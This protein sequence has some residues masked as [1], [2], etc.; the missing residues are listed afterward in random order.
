MIETAKNVTISIVIPTHNRPIGLR[1][2]LKSIAKQTKLPKEVIVVDDGSNPIVSESVFRD[3]PQSVDYILL[4]NEMPKGGNN[5]RNQGIMIARGSFIAFLDDDDRF[6]PNKIE[7]VQREINFRPDTDVLYHPAHIHMVNEGA[8]YHSKLYNFKKNDNIFRA[9]LVQNFVGGTSMVVV[10]RQCLI[11]VGMFDEKMPALQD[12][13]MWLR[14]SKRGCKFMSINQNLTN[15]YHITR[16]SS[17][18]KN[19]H[20]NIKAV[21]LIEEKYLNEYTKLNNREIRA[22][23][24]WKKRM[25]IHKTLLNGQPLQAIKYQWRLF[26][27]SPSL[28][29]FASIFVMLLGPKLIFKIKSKIG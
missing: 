23:N 15:Y 5:A 29:N 13:E 14:L 9:L 12:Y 19:V 25:I 20:V 16:K 1:E 21:S 4:R 17:V 11:D 7:V 28:V 26:L 18:S 24:I 10:R 2:A 8:S 3:L 22:H 27:Y 6:K